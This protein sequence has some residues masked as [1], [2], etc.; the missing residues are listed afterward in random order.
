MHVLSS[1]LPAIGGVCMQMEDEISGICA[2]L[3]AAM[4][5]KSY[6]SIKWTWNFTKI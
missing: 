5:K 1:K 4:R 2:S 3:G 6:D